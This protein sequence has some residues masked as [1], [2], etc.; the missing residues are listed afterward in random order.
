MFMDKEAKPVYELTDKDNKEYLFVRGNTKFMKDMDQKDL[1]V[2]FANGHQN[3]QIRQEPKQAKEA[4]KSEA[5]K[6]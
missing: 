4:A 1:E 3:V 5:P 6:A 2:L